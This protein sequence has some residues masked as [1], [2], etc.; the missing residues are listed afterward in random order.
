MDRREYMRRYI[1]A[2]RAAGGRRVEAALR[3]D[4]LE[5]FEAVRRWIVDFN[6]RMVRNGSPVRLST[7]DQQVIRTALMIAAGDRDR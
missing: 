5:N 4:D 7:S 1:A 2:R 3:E 6:E